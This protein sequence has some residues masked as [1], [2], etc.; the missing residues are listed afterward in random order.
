MEVLP[1]EPKGVKAVSVTAIRKGR[2]LIA[3]VQNVPAP[4]GSSIKEDG[5]KEAVVRGRIELF[6]GPKAHLSD[7]VWAQGLPVIQYGGKVIFTVGDIPIQVGDDQK[8]LVE[9]TR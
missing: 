5:Y 2:F 8:L 4:E 3:P 6:L 1:K 9:I 7:E